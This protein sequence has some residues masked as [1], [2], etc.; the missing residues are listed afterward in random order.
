MR[1]LRWE[2]RCSVALCERSPRMG[3]GGRPDILGITQNRYLLEI[4][5][6]RSLSDFHANNQKLHVRNRHLYLD[7]WP[8]NFWFLVPADLAPKVQ[9]YVP[10]WAGLLRAPT[11]EE[12]QQ[13]VV[14][15]KSPSNSKSERLSTRE[16]VAL[17]HCM[18]NQCLAKEEKINKLQRRL[19]ELTN[20]HARS[21]SCGANGSDTDSDTPSIDRGAAESAVST[22]V[23]APAGTEAIPSKA[24]S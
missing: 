20:S 22:P 8:K 15:K 13:L 10:E 18:A 6:K 14:L 2:K 1:W 9:P 12:V 3:I 7:R 16:M 23:R 24:S 5:I 11:R 21:P 17:A 4:E 19:R